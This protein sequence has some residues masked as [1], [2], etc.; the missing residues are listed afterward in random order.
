MKGSYQ[1]CTVLT[2]TGL[3]HRRWTIPS[4]EAAVASVVWYRLPARESL[5]LCK[6]RRPAREDILT[7]NQ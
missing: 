2:P 4:V 3:F 7:G 5:T 1:K 6:K